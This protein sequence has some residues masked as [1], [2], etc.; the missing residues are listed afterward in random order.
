MV[1]TTWHAA[2]IHQNGALYWCGKG[3]VYVTVR[4][5]PFS[6]IDMLEHFLVPQLDVNDV[7]SQQ[8]GA[9]PHYHR[10]VMRYLN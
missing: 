7:I 5:K 4:T 3:E 8:D 1:T 10:D 2:V 9:P 6:N